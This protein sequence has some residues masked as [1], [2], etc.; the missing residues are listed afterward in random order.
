MTEPDDRFAESEDWQLAEIHAGIADLDAGLE[1]SH[2]EVA[3]WLKSWGTLNEPRTKEVLES[4]L[5]KAH[6]PCSSA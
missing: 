4:L 6:D 5:R 1:V 3:K 2:E